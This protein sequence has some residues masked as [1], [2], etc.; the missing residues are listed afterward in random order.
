MAFYYPGIDMQLPYIKRVFKMA[1]LKWSLIIADILGIPIW[2]IGIVSNMDNI[3][4]AILFILGL[5][6]V[7]TR[8]YFFVIQKKQAIR[9]KEID[10]WN[11]EQD[12]QDRIKKSK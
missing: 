4:S 6:Y 1:T 9:E 8:M 10:L 3:R 12:K 11:K 2:M 7:M 5:M